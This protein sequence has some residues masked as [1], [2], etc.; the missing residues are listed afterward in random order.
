MK[1][2]FFGDSLTWGGYGGDYVGEIK[3]RVGEKHEIIN[4]GVGGNTVLNLSRRLERDVLDH[5]PDAVFVMVGGNDAVSYSQP[6]TRPYYRKSMQIP[7]GVVSPDDFRSAYRDLINQLQAHYIHTFIGLE[8]MEA[9]PTVSAAM[10][11]YNALARAEAEAHNVPVLDLFAH[12]VPGTIPERRPISTKFI[13]QIGERERTGFS[14]WY[15]EQ[16]AHGYAYTFDGV[17]WTP[18]AAAQAAQMIVKFMEL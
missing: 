18:E 13:Q 14:D 1:V 7:E 6:D 15:G 10:K 12:F 17:H 4:T 9:N 16:K 2:V 3:Q 5:E 8:P 11:Q